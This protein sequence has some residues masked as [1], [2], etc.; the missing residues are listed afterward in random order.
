MIKRNT[1]LAL[2]KITKAKREEIRNKK[3]TKQENNKMAGIILMYQ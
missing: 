1:S 3:S 2:Q